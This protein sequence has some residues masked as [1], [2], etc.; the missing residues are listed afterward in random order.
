MSISPPDLYDFPNHIYHSDCREGPSLSSTG[1]RILA[2]QCPAAYKWQKENPPVKREFEIGNATHLLVLEP[3][4]YEQSIVRIPMDT[5]RTKESKEIRDEARAS[6]RYPLTTE[7]QAHVDG[8]RASLYNDPIAQFALQ[9]G[10]EVERSIF[11]RD[12]E[13][14]G[15]WVKCR[16]DIMPKTR[17]YLADVKTTTNASPEAFSKAIYSYGYHA[18][19]AAYGWVVEL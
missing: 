14:E 17:R 9:G 10:I 6:G 1:A 13:F 12:P 11:G 7:D 8:M 18:Q 15:Q 4:L 3:H 2:T 16:P 19:A 5:Y